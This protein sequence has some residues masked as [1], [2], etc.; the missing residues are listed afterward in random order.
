MCDDDRMD[1]TEFEKMLEGGRAILDMLKDTPIADLELQYQAMDMDGDKVISAH[2]MQAFT[3]A[4]R[5][6]CEQLE[7]IA[8]FSDERMAE[9]LAGA[10]EKQEQLLTDVMPDTDVAM[11]AQERMEIAK[12]RVQSL[13]ELKGQGMEL[14]I[15]RAPEAGYTVESPAEDNA[16]HLRESAEL[17]SAQFCGNP[18]LRGF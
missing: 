9:L 13:L 5:F 16:R 14:L 1:D 3:L 12:E 7:E 15:S 2:E 17:A 18:S 11:S 10:D 6:D 8:A 4:M